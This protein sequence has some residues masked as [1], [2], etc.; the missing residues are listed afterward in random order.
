MISMWGRMAERERRLALLT[1]GVAVVVLAYFIVSRAASNL[2]DLDAAIEQQEI[3]LIQL[4][5]QAAQADVVEKAYSRVAE[6]H[7]SEWTRA[8]I[9]DQ[10]SNEILRLA[11]VEPPPAGA[12]AQ[13]F[14]GPALVSFEKFSSGSLDDRGDG[15]REYHIPVKTKPTSI[16]NV[17]TFLQRIQES[18]QHLRVDRI[19]ID[20]PNPVKPV[21]TADLI[22]VRAIVGEK[23]DA[24]TEDDEG[25]DENLLANAS[26]EE[27][28]ATSNTFPGWQTSGMAGAPSGSYATDGSQGFEGSS[29]GEES[30]LFQEVLLVAGRTHDL[31]ADIAILGSGRLEVFTA[32]GEEPLP[33]GVELSAGDAPSHYRIRFTVP[34]DLE[35]ALFRAPCVVVSGGGS[36][37]FIDHVQLTET[38]D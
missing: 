33:G 13:D 38:G 3:A 27:W 6:E 28:D 16:E 21:V 5:Q 36:R 32:D 22:V 37:L 34:D 20:R 1:L 12:E 18:D 9:R 15:Y 26:F 30:R 11:L 14:A 8:K 24:V 17:C 23:S 2:R 25:V 35:G 7:S 31:L 10:L 4:T 29:E 19:V